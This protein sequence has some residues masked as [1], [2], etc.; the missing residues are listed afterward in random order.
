MDAILQY[1]VRDIHI[2]IDNNAALTEPEVRLGLRLGASLGGA[3]T[4]IRNS[5]PI[6][7]IA[8]NTALHAALD[9]IGIRQR[10]VAHTVLRRPLHRYSSF[11]AIH[12]STF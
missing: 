2:R 7:P 5:I 10:I 8:K 9:T 3:H 6:I 1:L 11:V 12:G 4:C